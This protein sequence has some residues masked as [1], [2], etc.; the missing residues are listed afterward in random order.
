MMH[1]HYPIIALV[2][3]LTRL[4]T[5][6]AVQASQLL[7][8]DLDSNSSTLL[9]PTAFTIHNVSGQNITFFLASNN[10]KFIRHQITDGQMKE[11][12]DGKSKTYTIKLPT[13]NR[14]VVQCT[15]QASQR[16]QI[17]WNDANNQWDIT[18]L[19]PR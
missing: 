18:T 7:E 14:G 13:A 19:T 11:Y 2:A 1:N 10:N 8:I 6:S 12:S 16:Y 9:R 15:L 17:Y 3:G 5:V 4:R